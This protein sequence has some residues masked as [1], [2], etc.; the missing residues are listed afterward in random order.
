MFRR[1][2]LTGWEVLLPAWIEA[3]GER[4]RTATP[5][6]YVVAM[7]RH[8]VEN[9]GEPLDAK[10]IAA[11]VGL[12]PNYALNLFTKVMQ[13]SVQ[14]FVVRMRLIWARSLMMDGNLSIANIA[15][16]CGFTSLTQFYEHFRKAYGTTPR[17]LRRDVVA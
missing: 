11:V 5:V 8:I 2:A 7:V 9:L 17:E 6:R 15:Y 4:H 14:K 1:A 16:Q 12:H 10:S 3:P 13:I